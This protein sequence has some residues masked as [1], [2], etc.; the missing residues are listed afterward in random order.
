[1]TDAGE[2]S[3]LVEKYRLWL[4][5][6]TAIKSVH[7][8]WVE[9]TTPFLDR[10]NDYIQIYVKGSGGSYLLSDDGNTL[11]D[12]EMSG[13]SIDTPKRKG[14]LTVTLNGFSI[15]EDKGELITK[16]TAENFPLRKHALVQ[17]ILAVNDLFYLASSTV[18]SLFREDVEKWLYDNDIRFVPNIQFPG[19]SGYQHS[20]DFAIPRSRVAPERLLRAITNP[21]RDAAL[22]FISAWTDTVE[23][24]PVDSVPVA[25]LNDNRGPVTD[26]VTDALRQYD[27]I[28]VKWSLRETERVRLAA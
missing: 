2:I 27:I 13:C 7:T 25:F 16:A 11:R 26:A 23:Q 12:L 8:D 18:R 4:K 14:I 5:D 9:I 6:R 28:P 24:R 3:Q 1:M 10:H 15:Q 19:K 20:F 17:A 21:N 22:N